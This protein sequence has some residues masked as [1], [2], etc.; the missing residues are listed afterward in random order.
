MSE[1][2]SLTWSDLS[3]HYHYK[4][5]VSLQDDWRKTKVS[6]SIATAAQRNGLGVTLSIKGEK[7]GEEIG[8]GIYFSNVEEC[9]EFMKIM[10][11]HLTLAEREQR[12]TERHV[13][14]AADR[15]EAEDGAVIPAGEMKSRGP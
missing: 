10:E 6:V 5:Y 3:V 15:G 14:A 7:S 1:D 13:A 8:T 2:D 11:R 9:R 12:E 4:G